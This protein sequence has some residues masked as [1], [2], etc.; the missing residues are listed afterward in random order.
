M[1]QSRGSL[2]A[3]V[4]FLSFAIAALGGCG[5]SSPGGTTGSGD[6]ADGSTSSMNGDGVSAEA[7]RAEFVSFPDD[8]GVIFVRDFGAIPD[9]DTDDTD[10]IQKA[11]DDHPS[12]NHIFYFERGTYLVS[13]T[14]QPALDDG[15]TKRNIFQGAG[16]DLTTLRVPDNAGLDGAMISFR[17]GPAQFFRNSVRDLTLEVGAGNPMAIGLQFNASNQGTVKRV[18]IKG[19]AESAIGLDLSA[20]AEVGPC[21]ISDLEIDGFD[22]GVQTRFQTASQTLEH[23]KLSNQG[24]VGWRNLDAQTVFGRDWTIQGAENPVVNTAEGR[25]LLTDSEITGNGSASPAI[26]NQKAVYL[27]NIETTGYDAAVS[28]NLTAG[29]GN[30]GFAAD[31]IIEYWANGITGSRR[32]GAFKLFDTPDTMLGLEVRDSPEVPWQKQELWDGP[33]N[34]GG[35]PDD[36]VDDTQAIQAAI[37]SGARTVYLPRG[38]WRIEGEVSLPGSL[39]HFLGTEARIAGGGSLVIVGDSADPLFV[40]RLENAD[41]ELVHRSGRVAVL[42]H[43]LGANYSAESSDA[44]DVYMNDITASTIAFKQQRVW[45]RQLNL[46]SEPSERGRDAK[47]TNEG[48]QVWVLGLKTE[49]GGTHIKTTDGGSTELYGALHVGGADAEPRFVTIDSAFSGALVKGGSDLVSETRNGTTREGNFGQADA[50]VAYD[51]SVI[52]DRVAIVDS[53]D[54]AGVTRTG[55]WQESGSIPGGFLGESFLFAAAGATASVTY[56]PTLAMGTYEVFARWV[57]DRSGQNHSGHTADAKYVVRDGSGTTEVTLDQ[58]T[59]G[60]HWVSLGSFTTNGSSD[61]LTV[62]L[63]AGASGTVIADAIR[64]AKA[65]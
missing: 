44:G 12:G 43:L 64:F 14:L 54:S 10:A 42:Q 34:H 30:E 35:S 5:D 16:R 18:R 23:M 40:E 62:T 49:D 4:V 41:V 1:N 13:A 47:L 59:G 45:A 55:A 65:P 2:S 11:L 22:V 15:V 29:R 39:V 48:G 36:D 8:S 57:S 26:A 51:A 53:E 31:R 19:P 58:R 21:L 37:D 38:T 3:F 61:G 20:S 46:E 33:Q 50:L 17:A 52:Q 25:L 32:G 27:R 56:A 60:G 7:T 28:N 9:D 63:A 24:S 6:G